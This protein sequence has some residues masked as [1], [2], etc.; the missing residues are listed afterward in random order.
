VF[1]GSTIRGE[2]VSREIV[3]YGD[4]K[5]NLPTLDRIESKKG[6]AVI[7]KLQTARIMIEEG[8]YF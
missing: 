4:V 8:A 3:I 6:G 7:G 5:D 1:P 2:I